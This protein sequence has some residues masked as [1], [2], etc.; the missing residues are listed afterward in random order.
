MEKENREFHESLRRELEELAEPGFRDFTSRLMP[1]VD[2]VL[3]VRLPKLRKIAKRIAKGDWESYL[4]NASDES[5]EEIMLQGMVI[6]CCKTGFEQRSWQIQRFVPKIDNWSVCD[7]FCAGLKAAREEPEKM[8]DFLQ[9][10]LYGNGTYE[11]R[12]AVVMLLMY[13]REESYMDAAFTAFDDI[14]H[15]DYYVKMAVAWAVSMYFAAYPA[16]TMEYL[17]RCRLDDFTYRRALQKITE[18]LQ[19]DPETKHKVRELKK[20]T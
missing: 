3:G 7:S 15:E 10:Y 4:S 13:Y 17:K 20:V 14:R 2:N 8:W 1:G 12:F 16:Q 19:V 9:P 11:I 6:G 18:S 5:Y